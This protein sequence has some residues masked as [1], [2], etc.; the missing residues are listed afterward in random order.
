M[1]QNKTGPQKFYFNKQII[2]TTVSTLAF[3]TCIVM[4]YRLFLFFI[5]KL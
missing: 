2:E 4:S 3:E 5:F 1:K